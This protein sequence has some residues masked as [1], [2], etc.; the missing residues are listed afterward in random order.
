M[1]LINKNLLHKAGL[2][3]FYVTDFY[4]RFVQVFLHVQPL[5]YRKIESK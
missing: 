5:A 3:Q 2:K 1:D 4:F